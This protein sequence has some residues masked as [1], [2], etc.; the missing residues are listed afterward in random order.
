METLENLSRRIATTKDL[1]SI[2]RTMKSLSAVSIRQYERAVAALREYARATELGLQVLLRESPLLAVAQDQF[3]GPTAAIVFGSDHGLCARFNEQISRFAR[4]EM[5]TRG[6]S[7]EHM[8]Y[9][10]VGVQAASRLEAMGQR[11]DERMYLPGSVSGLTTTAHSLLLKIDEWRSVR[12]LARVLVF[13]NVRSTEGA[14]SPVCHQLLP[15]NAAWLNEMGKRRWPSHVL[16]TFTMD[17]RALFSC[18]IREH[19][20]VAI[21]RAGAESMASEHATRLASMQAAERNIQEHLEE[22]NQAFHHRRQQAITEELL[23]IVGGFETLR[24]AGLT[25][26]DIL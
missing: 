18:L 2:V 20:F 9:L 26:K 19:L 14:A 11:V 12:G 10:A 5:T 16:P 8:A 17:S 3:D 25:G 1:Q 24:T 21:F 22:M 23:D 4:A 15:L 6:V 13:H 7:T